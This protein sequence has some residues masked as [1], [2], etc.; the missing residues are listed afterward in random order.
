MDAAKTLPYAGTV[1]VGRML[2]AKYPPEYFKGQAAPAHTA[3]EAWQLC[4]DGIEENIRLGKKAILID[5]QPRDEEQAEK[6]MGLPYMH[7]FI[8]L[9]ASIEVRRKRAIARDRGGLSDE[10]VNA[11]V[12]GQP[13]DSSLIPPKLQLSLDR[14]QNDY[15]NGY[16][17]LRVLTSRGRRVSWV[18]T[19]TLLPSEY[20]KI[21]ETSALAWGFDS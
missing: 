8:G 16:E 15:R 4:I 17:V 5:G 11:L 18:N 10:I 21:V 3:A 7:V 14:L 1:E 20:V 9:H 19:D 2:R 6:V 12:M 13:V